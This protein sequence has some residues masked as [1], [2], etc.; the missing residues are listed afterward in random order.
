ME[1]KTVRDRLGSDFSPDMLDTPRFGGDSPM[2]PI[3]G[4]EDNASY[5]ASDEIKFTFF[6]D[7]IKT[8]QTIDDVDRLSQT[9]S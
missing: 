9:H 2:I 6:V 5:L 4:S 1:W 3:N 8:K 7:A